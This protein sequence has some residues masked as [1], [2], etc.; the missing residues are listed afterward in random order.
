MRKE[1]RELVEQATERGWTWEF[2]RKGH[3][4]LKHPNGGTM[5]CGTTPSDH[6]GSKNAVARMK[7]IERGH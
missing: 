5:I 1:V 6:R 7:R 2:T 3:L 4:R